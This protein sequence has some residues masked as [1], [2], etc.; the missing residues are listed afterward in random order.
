MGAL[1]TFDG[2]MRVAQEYGPYVRAVC[3]Q[4]PGSTT[5]ANSTS[6]VIPG[7]RMLNPVV[8]PSSFAAGVKGI[9]F[10]NISG[11]VSNGQTM[12]LVG[13]EYE[14]GSLNMSTGVFSAGVT[15]PTKT[16]NGESV[17]TAAMWNFL[18]ADINIS[19][20]SPQIDVTYT[21]QAG[22]ASRTAT[23]T[24]PANPARGSAFWVTRYLQGDDTG[25][26]AVTNMTK[27][28]GTAGTLKFYGLLPLQVLKS[29]DQGVT[30]LPRM[31]HAAMPPFIATASEKIAMYRF[32][33]DA[34]AGGG[35]FF[36]NLYGLPEI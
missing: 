5:A 3:Y 15:M 27:S 26:R 31:A 8:L 4:H 13:L 6:G 28:A 12:G 33:R 24:L 23:L 21:N 20:S 25:V 2:M 18:V 32:G 22:T 34:Y 29:D 1:D 16:I 30:F 7:M 17:Q 36:L 35:N 9:R 10:I 11:F 14:L 19:A